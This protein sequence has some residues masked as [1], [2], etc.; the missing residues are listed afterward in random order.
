MLL[1]LFCCITCINLLTNRPICTK[2]QQVAPVCSKLRQ[3]AASCTRL[4]QVARS[5]TKLHQSAPSG[6]IFPLIIMLNPLMKWL[7]GW[8]LLEYS[9]YVVETLL[10]IA[11]KGQQKVKIVLIKT[12]KHRFP[13]R[14]RSNSF[15]AMK[16]IFACGHNWLAILHLWPKKGCNLFF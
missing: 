6:S 12:P 10:C 2:L 14:F 7:L 4:H 13:D 3:S 1:I 5:C 9:V 8:N 15:S 16:T 11:I